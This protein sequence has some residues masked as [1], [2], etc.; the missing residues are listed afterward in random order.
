MTPNLPIS[1]DTVVVGRSAKMR[2]VF[3]FLRV[4]SGSEST[5]LITGESGT[6]KEVV[7]KKIYKPYIWLDGP[8]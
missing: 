8:L 4:I 5:V 2:A 1:S 7:A 6:G 3:D